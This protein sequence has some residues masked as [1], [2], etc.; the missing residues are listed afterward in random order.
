MNGQW[1]WRAIHGLDGMAMVFNGSQ[2]LAKR[3]I[4]S[5]GF[6]G[7]KSTKGVNRMTMVCGETTIV[8]DGFQW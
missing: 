4:V 3:S 5:N 7:W 2:L 1:F 8:L 6:N